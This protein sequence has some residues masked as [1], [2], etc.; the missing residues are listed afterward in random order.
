M[1]GS[2]LP[3]SSL[4]RSNLPHTKKASRMKTLDERI[5]DLETKMA[6]AIASGHSEAIIAVSA[7]LA[8][9]KKTKKEM[10]DDE[11][12]DGDDD[13]KKAAKAGESASAAL[14]AK[15]EE[16]KKSKKSKKPEEDGDDEEEEEKKAAKA[17]LA[18][19]ESQ[20]GRKGSAALG[21]AMALFARMDQAIQDTAALKAK[22]DADERSSLLAKAGKYVPPHLVA[23]LGTQKISALRAFVEEAS[24]GE[25]MVATE[26]GHL[27]Q[28]KSAT[29]GTE[30]ALPKDVLAMIDDAVSN[31]GAADPKA[32][33]ATLVKAHL[34]SHTA[35]VRNGKVTY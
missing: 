10:D 4:T 11:E 17:S 1:P 5:A 24:K 7:S 33:R 22:S 21:A 3:K 9:A 18:L 29:P 14:L 26:E 2:R 13:A 12:E 27:F 19:I 30:A 25:P 23:A 20:T 35:S 6:S 16:E 28:P 8:A 31:C 34:D 32:F 15:K